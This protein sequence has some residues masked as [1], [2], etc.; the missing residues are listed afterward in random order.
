[1]IEWMKE[2]MERMNDEI[3]EKCKKEMKMLEKRANE[4]KRKKENNWL[5]SDF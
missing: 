4:E 1:M 5:P 3:S 2:G